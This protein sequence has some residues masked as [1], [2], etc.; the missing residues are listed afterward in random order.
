MA[1]IFKISQLCPV[2]Q[3]AIIINHNTKSITL[4]ALMSALRYANVPV[5]LIDCASTDGSF[6][7]FKS[8]MNKYDFDL[9]QARLK[10]HGHTLDQIFS[11]AKDEKILLVDS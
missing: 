2:P 4:L 11:S 8:I 6:E 9:M 3:R 1:V 5:L 10:K 7:F